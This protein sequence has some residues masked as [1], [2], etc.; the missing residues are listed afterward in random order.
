MIWGIPADVFLQFHVAVSLI[1]IASGLV[2]LYGLVAKP[3][4]GWTVLFLATTIL[5]GVT[6][7]LVAAL[8]AVL[9]ASLLMALGVR[10]IA[11]SINSS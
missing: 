10:P 7:S 9:L 2:V 3:L 6:I 1:A 8:L 4:A 5:T 11:A